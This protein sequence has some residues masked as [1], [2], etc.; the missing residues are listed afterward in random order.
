MTPVARIATLVGPFLP[1]VGSR[2]KSAPRTV[3]FH[4]EVHMDRSRGFTLIELV[5]VLAIIGILAAIAYPMYQNQVRKSNRAAAQA[6]LMDIANKQQFYLSSQRQ[7]ASSYAD[8]GVTLSNE[9]TRFYTIA[10]APADGT[11][12][13]FTV[14]ATPVSGTVQEADGAISLTSTGVKSP[15]S[16]W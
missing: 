16:K 15:A 6:A 12:P 5:V 11:P 13:T 1:F 8:L 14:T 7:Y 2:L 4:Q 3:G 10:V 9:V